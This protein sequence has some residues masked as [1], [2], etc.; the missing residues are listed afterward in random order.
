MRTKLFTIC[1]MGLL[2]FGKATSQVFFEDNF[3]KA[4]EL[5][6]SDNSLIKAYCNESEEL[7]L[8]VQPRFNYLSI[9]SFESKLNEISLL[10]TDL[11]KLKKIDRQQFK[12]K[13]KLSYKEMT[14][15]FYSEF[16]NAGDPCAIV[17]F[18][19]MKNDFILAEVT[20][21]SKAIDWK[22]VVS[23]QR[24]HIILFDFREDDVEYYILPITR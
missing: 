20:F 17:S 10:S 9:N 13:D 24:S 11:K 2:L 6:V 14:D 19:R 12:Q 15:E 8:E 4:Y 7:S 1:L 16:K 23:N 5:L 21:Y 3:K 22:R 18:D